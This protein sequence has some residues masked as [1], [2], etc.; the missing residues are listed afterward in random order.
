MAFQQT[1][2]F[3]SLEN[4]SLSF[5]SLVCNL[6]VV[7]AVSDLVFSAPQVSTTMGLFLPFI[8]WTCLFPTEQFISPKPH[9]GRGRGRE[10]PLLC[11]SC[12]LSEGSTIDFEHLVLAP[13]VL[14][15][16]SLPD[17]KL[18]NY[19]HDAADSAQNLF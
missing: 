19:L 5:I 17:L 9:R 12:K 2:L 3:L 15:S 16:F 18:V 13:T 10:E 7:I 14:G 6:K 11:W 8:L 1:C 4:L